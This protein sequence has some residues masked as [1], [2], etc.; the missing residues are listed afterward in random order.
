[1]NSTNVIIDELLPVNQDFKALRDQGLAYI[2]Q[3]SGMEWTNLNPSDPGVTILDQVCYALTELGYCNDFSVNDLLTR[4]NGELH[5][6]DQFY[7]PEDIMTVSP[8]TTTDYRKYLIDGVEGINNAVVTA[9]S[10]HWAQGI[11]QIYLSIDQTVIANSDPKKQQT[12]I[13]KVCKAAFFYLNKSRNI[14]EFFL[15][16]R[17]LI[18]INVAVGGVLEIDNESNWPHILPRIELAIRNYIF[19]EVS[20][21]SYD[22][23]FNDGISAD[24]I[25]NGPRLKNG[26][27]ETKALGENRSKLYADELNN[28]VSSVSGVVSSQLNLGIMKPAFIEVNPIYE[29]ITVDLAGVIKKC[30]NIPIKSQHLQSLETLVASS[31]I[32]F[33]SAV[34]AQ[35][36]L[37][38]GKFRDVNT[39]YAIQNTFPEIFAVGTDSVTANAPDFDIARS[40]QLKGYLTLFDQV[41]A[42]QFSQLANVNRLFSFKNSLTG[43][44]SDEHEFYAVKDDFEKANPE[45]PA[46]YQTFS[47]TYF[48]QSLYNVP[49]IKPLLKDSDAFKFSVSPESKK[50]L[51]RDSWTAYKHDP[52]NPYIKGLMTFIEDDQTSLTRRNDILDHLLA[53]HGESPILINEI[54]EGSV[55]TSDKLKDKV[56][57]KSL[58]L[59]N[60]GLL[61]YYAQKGYNML[62]ATRILELDKIM[63]KNDADAFFHP[64]RVPGDNET[65]FIFNST[66]ID[67][68]EKLTEYDFINYSAAQL[69]L[70]LLFGLKPLYQFFIS[71]NHL[72]QESDIAIAKWM[73]EQQRGAIFI[74]TNLINLWS[75]DYWVK[76]IYRIGKATTKMWVFE[77]NLNLIELRLIEHFFEQGLHADLISQLINEL[78]NIEGKF[79]KVISTHVLPS[80]QE[81]GRKIAGTNLYLQSGKLYHAKIEHKTEGLTDI[82]TINERL[83]FNDVKA[84]EQFFYSGE[85]SDIRRQLDSKTLKIGMLN[86]T[87]TKTVLK[88]A[89]TVQKGHKIAGTSYYFQATSQPV[90][91][92]DL[93]AI[94]PDRVFFKKD[95]NDE[96]KTALKRKFDLFLQN[97]LPVQIDSA[98]YFLDNSALEALIP[99]FADWHNSCICKHPEADYIPYPVESTSNLRNILHQIIKNVS[100]Q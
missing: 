30:K 46:P 73:I 83:F 71:H 95:T 16:P 7:L 66:E 25:F 76:I 28:L 24:E 47:P 68:D 13:D 88:F 90:F 53:R 12:N 14:G 62:G 27:I 97:T 40:R 50:E 64:Y 4:S 98:C 34:G 92:K 9:I 1:M 22:E 11:Y 72:E 56:I 77:K 63:Q 81:G 35:T 91:D 42:N 80:Y 93:I 55:Y 52:Y 45:Y 65:D 2:Q 78:L 32:Q 86:Y 18:P 75:Q 48:Y 20:Q 21:K 70:S 5:I 33:G 99:A 38:K 59:Q 29:I 60:L 69:K 100:K 37:P 67:D 17:A 3:Y 23:L 84:M 94:F 54:I 49:H 41:L 36:T 57:F 74:E 43:T 82:W 19:P 61:S 6:T 58:Y 44:P 15:E 96:T 10:S 51:E 26:W 8:L 85:H 39:Y 89:G 31:T 87:V 79:F